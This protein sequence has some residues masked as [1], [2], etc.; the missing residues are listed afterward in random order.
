V[1]LAPLVVVF[2]MNSALL[3]THGI[4]DNNGDVFGTQTDATRDWVDAIVPRG[5]AVALLQV[6]ATCSRSLAYD[7]LLTGFFNDRVDAM[8]QIGGE[9]YGG[10]PNELAHVRKTGRVAD[11][12]GQLLAADWVVAPRGVRLQGRPVAM[13]AEDHLVLWHVG[14][15]RVRLR[16]SSDR[17][18]EADACSG[19]A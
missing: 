9:P 8:P 4:R 15:P 7:Y 10:L 16:A 3:W 1:L 12:N 2:A 5:Q 13:G 6:T 14:T 17:Q 11:H 18:V 19:E